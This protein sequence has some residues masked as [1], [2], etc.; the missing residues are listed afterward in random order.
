MVGGGGQG[1]V[2]NSFPYKVRSLRTTT[3]FIFVIS[4]F[5]SCPVVCVCVWGGGG[6]RACACV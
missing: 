2:W 6:V 3:S 4:H 5:L 1:G